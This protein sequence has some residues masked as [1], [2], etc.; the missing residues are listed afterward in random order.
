MPAKSPTLLTPVQ[1]RMLTQIPAGLTEREIARHYTL[2]TEE[3]ALAR[4]RHG[5]ANKLG[6]AMQVAALH[7][8][9][10]SLTDL[11][12]IPEEVL[13]YVATQMELPLDVFFDYGER[14]A[15]LYDHLA[16]IRE[17][18]GYQDY[19]GWSMVILA[20]HLMP[21]ALESDEHLPLIEE[22][23]E[24]LRAEH[25]IAPA[26]GTLERLVWRVLR[27][28]ARMTRRWMLVNV[29]KQLTEQLD[30]LLVTQSEFGQRSTLAW[31]R[32]PPGAPS[33]KNLYRLL[34]RVER[35]EAL[36]VP[37][38]STN[39]HPNRIRQLANRCRRYEVAA[40]ARLASAE[41]RAGPF[42]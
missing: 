36:D 34:E 13:V 10:R 29:D 16:V 24:Y 7:F 39:L 42:G 37:A 18:L 21:L 28:T 5:R 25:V 3:I 33:A 23:L 32:T 17:G 9:G 30:A 27:A 4:R 38:L 14:E 40:L 20:R 6:F 31:L 22:A 8:P 11:D 15:T 35:L 19:G 41:E 12:T 1:R 26:I 2:T